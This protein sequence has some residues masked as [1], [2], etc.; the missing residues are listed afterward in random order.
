MM[1][2][3]PYYSL[4]GSTNMPLMQQTQQ[5]LHYNGPAI[6]SSSLSNANVPSADLTT[7]NSKCCLWQ[8]ADD[9]LPVTSLISIFCNWHGADGLQCC[10]PINYDDVPH[11]FKT[12]HGIKGL[13]R[14]VKIRCDWDDCQDIVIR[15]NFVR[16]IREVHLNCKRS[17][18]QKS[19]EIFEV[20]PTPL[21]TVLTQDE[22]DA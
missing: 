7:P 8:G 16:H 19:E 21:L 12:V 4:P 18:G 5:E 15:H 22:L 20:T 2:Q 14:E 13:G 6:S 17:M 10:E 11:H 1:S 3:N 9:P